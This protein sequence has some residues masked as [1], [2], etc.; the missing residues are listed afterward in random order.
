[1]KLPNHKEAYEI[2]YDLMNCD[3]EPIH[4]I[5]YVQH[6]T[7]L[8]ACTLQDQTITNVTAN[9]STVFSK[10]PDAILGEPLRVLF[11]DDVLALIEAG[12]KKDNFNRINPI[13][14]VIQ[15]Q[16]YNLVV[17]IQEKLL[18]IEVEPRVEEASGWEQL[19][20]VDEAIQRMQGTSELEKLLQIT[21]DEVQLVTGYDRVMLYR[22]DEQ[23]NG[24]VIAEAK[25]EELEPFKGLHY[26]ASD[27]PKQAR[28]LYLLNKTR[29]I[30]DIES[31][32]NRILPSRNPL[33][34]QPLDLTYSTS[35]GTS[36][37][38]I[39]YLTNMG[40]RAT[41]SV[42]VIVEGKLWGLIACH[43]YADAKFLDFRVRRV[44]GFIGQ[45]LSG[46]LSLQ[47]IQEFRTSSLNADLLK[48]R[49]VEQLNRSW[50][51]VEGLLHGEVSAHELFDSI[52]VA[53]HLENT[54]HTQG[55]TP[56][57]GELMK[58]VE[59]LEK[60]HMTTHFVTNELSDIYPAAEKFKWR[61]SGILAIRIAKSS[62][63][64]LIWFRP[65]ESYVVEWGGK[66]GKVVVKTEDGSRMSPR[67]SFDKWKQQVDG[68]AQPWSDVDVQMALSIRNDVLDFIFQKYDELKRVN[69]EL[70]GSY[71]EL[72]SFS[73]TISHD[74]RSPLRGIDGF[75]EILSEDYEDK[76]DDYG[77]SLLKVIQD[78]TRKMNRLIDDILRL[79]QLGKAHISLNKVQL[80]PIL[81][82]IIGNLL[83]NEDDTRDISITVSENLPDIEGDRTMIYQLFQN[84]LSN[85]V[86]YTRRCDKARIS[87]T[88]K[89]ADKNG[90]VRLL[91]A[92]NGIG[93]APRYQQKIF[94]V[95]SRLVG[96]NE[97]EGT[98]IGL[99][100]VKKIVQSHGG[101]IEVES[102]VGEGST[103]TISLPIVE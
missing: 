45:I 20:Q 41:M 30:A 32:P 57:V 102:E 87:I 93:M 44:V 79:A 3:A 78:N 81:D 14:A 9:S 12:V 6:H 85:A 92:D 95:F 51:I 69:E 90:Y 23:Y 17:H 26:P 59:W 65:E 18:V 46:Y 4:Q 68:K 42:A 21:V 62:N 60:Q 7:V 74:L 56:N 72:E 66:P 47:E 50:D 91:V 16:P 48:S 61:A 71:K 1:M 70:Q 10:V 39:E 76:L 22:F 55:E 53:V 2:K 103:F 5:R 58:L 13:H 89:P 35:R 34:Q 77:K 27:I 40:V 100:I 29:I 99:S 80:Q 25:I 101:H 24:Q 84:L 15:Q 88:T 98:G 94:D 63:D 43:H 36:P 97:F 38:H 19:A 64:Y 33:T 54:W 31:K 8:V 73:Y 28:A 49:L 67:K 37:I 86:K 11:S 75:A 96:E 82:D 83:I 52:G